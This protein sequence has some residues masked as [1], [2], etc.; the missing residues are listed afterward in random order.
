MV[1][2]AGLHRQDAD[3]PPLHHHAPD[4]EGQ[5]GAA[6]RAVGG[7]ELRR[8]RALAARP[9]A[10]WRDGLGKVGSQET[11]RFLMEPID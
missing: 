3:R 10:P 5:A 7:G 1:L 8:P 9:E 6:S 4:Q 2:G 11:E